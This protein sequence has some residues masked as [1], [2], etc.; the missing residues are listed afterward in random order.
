[1]NNI[2]TVKNVIKRFPL[3]GGQEFEALHGVDMEVPQGKLTILKGRSGSGKTT[4]LNILSALD[5]ATSGEVLF[6]DR[7]YH[8][9]SEQEKELQRRHHI[10][11]IFQSV[12]LIP[13]M[14]AYENV[15]FGLRLAGYQGDRKARIT[16]VMQM[17]KMEDRMMHM[18]NQMSGGEQQRIAIARAVAHKPKIIFA[19]E[20]TGA[21]DTMSGIRVINLFREL[22]EQENITI[23]MTTHDPAMMAYGD[24][25]YEMQ[26][27]LLSRCGEVIE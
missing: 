6:E 22:I 25:V 13:I 17:M 4:L 12:A 27:G 15:D 7:A 24:V 21:L 14:S 16:E 19:D 20:P 18:P 1:M 26:D 23:V 9:M 3:G 2:M 5:D 11:F 10:G 8:T